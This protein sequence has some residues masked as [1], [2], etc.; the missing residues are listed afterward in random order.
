MPGRKKTDP[1]KKSK[2]I[3]V[4]LEPDLREQV[5]EYVD[6]YAEHG[7][8]FGISA[9]IRA[10]LRRWTNREDPWPPPE[11]IEAENRRPSRRRNRDD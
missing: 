10:M 1:R 5:D 8:K 9:L 7:Q 6:Y 3:Q 2:V 11:D 4:K